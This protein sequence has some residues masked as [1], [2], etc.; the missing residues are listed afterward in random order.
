MSTEVRKSASILAAF[1][2][3]GTKASS[4][5]TRMSRQEKIRLLGNKNNSNSGETEYMKKAALL[6]SHDNSSKSSMN[7]VKT[8]K[9]SP[10]KSS[11]SLSG[12]RTSNYSAYQIERT[13][14]NIEQLSDDEE[15]LDEG[16]ISPFVRESYETQK[17]FPTHIQSISCKIDQKY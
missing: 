1:K 3:R 11:L 17:L 9:I 8:Q 14:K 7:A 13:I 6:S 12:V 2:A 16:K 10:I 15:P 5:R 4:A